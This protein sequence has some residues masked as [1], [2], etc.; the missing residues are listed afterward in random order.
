MDNQETLRQALRDALAGE[1]I[2]FL[3][4]GAA[5]DARRKDGTPLPTGQELANSLASDCNMADGYPLDTITE[6]FLE[7]RSETALINALRKHLKVSEVGEAILALASVKWIRVWT[8]NYDDAFE[9]A[10]TKNRKDHYSLTTADEARNAQGNRFLVLHINGCLS[11]LK[12]TL[13][14]D[15][16]LTSQSYATKAFVDTEWSTIFRNDIQQCKAIIFVGYSLADIDIARLIF[17]PEIFQKKI[18]FID[19]QRMDPVLKAKLSKFGTIHAIGLDRFKSILDEETLAWTPP[20]YAEQYQSWQRLIIQDGARVASDDDFYDFVLQ[21]VCKDRLLLGQLESASDPTYMVVRACEADCIKHLGQ[22]SAVALLVASFANGK[23]ITARSIALKLV[24]EGRDVFLIDHPY[25]SAF[26]ELQ[27]LCRRD[28][29][30]VLIIENYTRNLEFV[31][32]FSRYARPDCGLL[33]TERAEIHELNSAALIDRANQRNLRVFD[34]DLLENEELNRFSAL[35]ELRGLWG[36]RAALSRIQKFAFLREECGR[37]LQAVLIEVV[38]SPEIK[39]RL[40]AIVSHFE[41]IEGGLRILIGLCLLQAIGELPRI[42]IVAELLD[43]GFDSFR[44]LTADHKSRQI[45]STH[46]GVASFRSPIIASAVLNGLANASVITEV[47]AE[48]IKRAHLGRN[49]DPYLGSIAKELMRFAN[50]ERILPDKGK[51]SALQNLYENLSSVATIRENPQF[52]LQY[53]MARLSLGELDLARRYFEQSYSYAKKI[54]R[55]DTF[56][57]DN[58]YCRL[59]LREAEDTANADEAFRAVDEALATLKKQVL[60]ENRHY[61]FRSAWTL[62]GVSRRHASAWTDAQKKVIVSAAG[63]LIDAAGRLESQVARS[64]AVVGGTQRLKKVIE[65]LSV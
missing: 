57:I 27:K 41:S 11:R 7:E 64:V 63:Y 21:G 58:H 45:V 15:F 29:D 16:V 47:V 61:P 9:I 59:L 13:T 25:E 52:W 14:S 43:L 34:L 1:A 46:S 62:E 33:L 4:A 48:C 40:A 56:Q 51:R 37:Q 28:R 36:E 18:H 8:T 50:L 3:G 55:Y 5:K 30:F 49:A 26:K 32:C 19:R 20:V 53:A 38:E 22:Q 44:K 39:T 35:L 60:R 31:E 23:T 42:D 6:Y 17:N 65:L 24:A 54:D 2:L 10:L 12:Q